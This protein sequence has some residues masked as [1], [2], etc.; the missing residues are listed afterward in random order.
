MMGELR[1]S[2]PIESIYRAVLF[3]EASLQSEITV[4]Q[5]A[6][7]TGYS[8]FHFIRTFNRVVQHTPYDYLMRRRL[9]EAA[10]ALTADSRRIIDVA[11]DFCFNSP[12]SFS[13]AFRRMFGMQPSQWREDRLDNP[14]LLMPPVTQADLAWINGTHFRRPAMMDRAEMSLLGLMTPLAAD[15]R[16]RQA[17]RARLFSD[18]DE[19]YAG[20]AAGSWTAVTMYLDANCARAYEFVGMDQ[21][22]LPFA[23]PGL[24]GFVL[25]AGK[26]VQMELAGCE[27]GMALKYLYF[28]WFPGAGLK[29]ARQMEIEMGAFDG[30]RSALKALFLP[31]ETSPVTNARLIQPAR[32]VAGDTLEGE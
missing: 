28:T 29:P 3:I 1:R 2:E 14:L 6:E 31:I 11:Q 27:R 13:R 16:D 23:A 17:Q 24:A 26:Y 5:V 19:L 7:S 22:G 32:Y 9:S 20:K 12:E 15:E 4:E 8:L 10:K 21:D 25:P 18:L 30:G